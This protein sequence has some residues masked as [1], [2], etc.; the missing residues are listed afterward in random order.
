MQIKVIGTGCDKCTRLYQNVQQAVATLGLTADVS[1]VEDLVE[2]VKM[3]VM[4][5]PALAVDGKVV[6]LGK[7]LKAEEVVKLLQKAQG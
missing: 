6:S 7:V 5:V 2:I 4:S 1:K 3:G